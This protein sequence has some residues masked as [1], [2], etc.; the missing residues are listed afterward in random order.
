MS[1][2]ELGFLPEMNTYRGGGVVIEPH[3]EIA[4][5]IE[6]LED[7]G[8]VHDG[9]FYP[10]STLVPPPPPSPRI[11]PLRYSLPD[12]HVLSPSPGQS[13]F[14]WQLCDLLITVLGF[15]RGLRLVPVGHYHPARAAT[16]IGQLVDFNCGAEHVEKALDKAAL[17]KEQ[18]GHAL[19]KQL[20]GAFHWYL[21]SQSYGHE[22]E[23]FTAQY[24]VL[25]SCWG[26]C[27]KVST[28]RGECLKRPRHS[29]RVEEMCAKF[30][31]P[32]P[33][34]AKVSDERSRLSELRNA[35]FHAGLFADEALGFGLPEENIV[36]ELI[37][38]NSRLLVGLL[39]IESDYVKLPVSCGMRAKL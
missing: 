33:S 3:P 39:G 29:E 24:I 36:N 21:A 23:V 13:S 28:P 4:N 16:H 18:Y 10:L 35:V 6:S 22:F 31:I 20:Y 2:G 27:R 9:W 25:D 26:L 15:F 34:W 12:T 8:E 17:F 32:I 5:R 11:P 38:L 30:L 1:V 7:Y 37:R 19:S 14:D